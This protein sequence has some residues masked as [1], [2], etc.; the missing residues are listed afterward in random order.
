[1]SEPELILNSDPTIIVEKILVDQHS[2]IIKTTESIT[3]FTGLVDTPKSYAGKKGQ[4]VIVNDTENGLMFGAAG[5][6]TVNCDDSSFLYSL[7][8]S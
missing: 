8:F 6:G 2:F 3:T 4:A 7:I 1:M 5:S